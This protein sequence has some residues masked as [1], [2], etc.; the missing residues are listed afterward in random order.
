M[1]RVSAS[2]VGYPALLEQ[3]K[4]WSAQC[5]D[6]AT[7]WDIRSWCQLSGV[8][9]RQ[10]YTVVMSVHCHKSVPVPPQGLCHNCEASFIPDR[11]IS[12]Y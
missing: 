1:S 6:N 12:E 11:T 2:R 9:V 10:H 8:P 3:G 7:E 4:G 5:Q